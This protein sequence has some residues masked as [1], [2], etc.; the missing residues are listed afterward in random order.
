ME[1]DKKNLDLNEINEIEQMKIKISNLKSETEDC[2]FALLK[3]NNWNYYMKKL[4]CIIG[5]APPNIIGNSSKFLNQFLSIDLLGI[6][7]FSVVDANSSNDQNG[8]KTG[9]SNW[10]VDIDLG[11][12]KKISK[13]HALIIYNFQTCSFEIKNL[14]K[15]CPI[16]V[17]GELLK[18]NEEIPL[19]SKSVIHI[20]NHEFYFMLPL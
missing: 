1:F 6:N 17:N 7:T 10:Y 4:N 8:N 14:S 12:N 9:Y 11:Q 3:G 16:K 18:Y 2:G 15:K 5:R 19:S 13:Q 20:G